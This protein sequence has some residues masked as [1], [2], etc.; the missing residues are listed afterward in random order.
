[1]NRTISELVEDIRLLTRGVIDAVS[2]GR[3]D[4]AWRVV[5]ATLKLEWARVKNRSNGSPRV[6][7]RSQAHLLP[8]KPGL[9]QPD[10]L[11]IDSKGLV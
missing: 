4:L 3:L 6:D 8:P 7:S 11:T 10:A 2:A 9:E 1:M 5:V